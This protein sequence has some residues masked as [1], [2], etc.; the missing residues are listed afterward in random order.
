VLAAT[1]PGIVFVT[2]ESDGA[3]LL[4]AAAGRGWSARDGAFFVDGNRRAELF[5]ALRQPAAFEGATGTAPSGPPPDSSAGPRLASFEAR[6][7]ARY[8]RG[9]ATNAE[10]HYDAAYLAALAIELAGSADEPEAIRDAI[11]RTTGGAPVLAG[12]WAGARAVIASHGQLDYQGASGEVDLDPGTGELLPPYY[13]RLWTVD[14]Q[15]IV[16][17]EFVTIAP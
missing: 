16:D 1:A 14:H 4:D 3:L 2:F 7:M 12:D 13:V 10:N 11:G 17:R 6:F 9:P 15:L 5:S 8:Q